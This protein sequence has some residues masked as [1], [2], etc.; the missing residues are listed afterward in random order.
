[1]KKE[2]LRGLVIEALQANG[3]QA[4][5]VQVCKHVWENNRAELESSGDL[6][7]TWQYDIRWAAQSLRDE[8]VMHAD[9][10]SPRGIWRLAAGAGA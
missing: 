7:Y 1:M 8:K 6:F 10:L 9:E 3:G 2:D 5:I 4:T